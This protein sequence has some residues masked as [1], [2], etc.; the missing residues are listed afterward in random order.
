MNDEIKYRELSKEEISKLNQLDRAEVIDDIYYV[1][2]G[3]LVLEKEHYD[4]PGWSDSEKKRRI[5]NLQKVFDE[6]ATFTGAFDR[7]KLVGMSILD[8]NLVRSGD[9]RLNLE[10]LWVSHKY[11]GK[12]VGKRLFLI[13]VKEAKKRNAKA[14]YVSATPSKNTV[15]FYQRLG[16]K[17]ADPVDEYLFKKEPEDIHLEIILVEN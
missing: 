2:G 3:V 4:V 17:R 5:E 13:A 9:N 6:G 14:M 11:R 7:N 1:R 12:G 16:C 15:H 10:G 8:H